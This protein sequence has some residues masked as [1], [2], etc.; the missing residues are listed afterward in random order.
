[1][2]LANS[3]SA[4]RLIDPN[5]LEITL[6]SVCHENVS[7]NSMSGEFSFHTVK[8]IENVPESVA[9]RDASTANATVHVRSSFG[10]LMGE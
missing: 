7:V 5:A 4:Y 9:Q 6:R 2:D 3:V 8:R 1:M 10:K